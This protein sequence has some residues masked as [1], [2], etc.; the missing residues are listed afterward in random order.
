MK[1]IYDN[2]T[3]TIITICLVG[4]FILGCIIHFDLEKLQRVEC[5]GC[6]AQVTD[7]WYYQN[8]HGEFVP[9]CSKCEELVV[10]E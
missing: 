2:A 10:E 1:N 6:G 7:V 9:L 8:S 4:I 3:K 5:G